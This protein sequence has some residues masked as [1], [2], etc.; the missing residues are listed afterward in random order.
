MSFN[1][2]PLPQ[3]KCIGEEPIGTSSTI[4]H[5][6]SS[7][8]LDGG[9]NSAPSQTVTM[10]GPSVVDDDDFPLEVEKVTKD[11]VE[12]KREINATSTSAF[13]GMMLLR[14]TDSC[15]HREI[16]RLRG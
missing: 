8:P 7:V 11:W 5:K 10:G 13:F 9:T 16:L 14:F 1:T 4:D 15:S 3:F 6:G 12:E 2:D